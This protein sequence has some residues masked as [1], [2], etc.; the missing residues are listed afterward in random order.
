MNAG[1]FGQPRVLK[2]VPLDDGCLHFAEQFLPEHEANALF[3]VLM[4]Q[5][6]WVQQDIT[7]FGKTMKEPRLSCWMG[8][9]EADYRYS[10]RHHAPVPWL[11][12]V[13]ELKQR[14]ERVLDGR[15]LTQP[16]NSVLLNRYRNGDD[17][18]ALHADDE[19]ELGANPV[20]ASVSLGET[21]D[22][23]LKHR[24][25]KQRKTLPLPHG[26]LLVMSGATQQHW[27]HGIPRVKGCHHERVNLTFRRIG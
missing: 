17:A 9:A 27:L 25:S 20:I 15:L 13:V 5:V 22:F 1:L 7:L 2:H 8:D 10:G 18:L 23:V 24:H 4:K 11:L 12:E 26:S 14:I 21:R 6:P 3:D 19:K 16:W